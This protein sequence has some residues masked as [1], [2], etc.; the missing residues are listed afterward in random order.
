[1]FSML[2]SLIPGVDS[3]PLLS[4]VRPLGTDGWVCWLGGVVEVVPGDGVAE[5]LLLC[6]ATFSVVSAEYSTAACAARTA[7]RSELPD[8][9]LPPRPTKLTLYAGGFPAE[10][11][12]FAAVLGEAATLAGDGGTR[13]GDLGTG[14]KLPSAL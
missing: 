1:M 6:V 10:V 11:A 12:V 5:E 9:S 3:F 7:E 4:S 2:D 8:A 14:L 13:P